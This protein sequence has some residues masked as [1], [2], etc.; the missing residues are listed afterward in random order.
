MIVKPIRTEAD[1]ERSLSRLEA[2]MDAEVGTSAGDELDVLASL[3][4]RYEDEQFPIV[5]PTPLAAIRFRMEQQNLTPRDLAPYIGSRARVS[6][7]LSGT[8]PLSIDMIRA[9]SQHLGIPADVLI[10]PE[11]D[12]QEAPSF[13][14]LSNASWIELTYPF[15]TKRAAM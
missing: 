1:Y 3:I 9:L 7:V 8:R 6:E 15:L 13:K 10:R 5:A 14:Y 11:P 12:Q 2:L 4:E